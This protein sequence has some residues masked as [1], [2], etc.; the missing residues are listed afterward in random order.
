MTIEGRIDAISQ[1][2]DSKDQITKFCALISETASNTA[3]LQVVANNIFAEDIYQQ[4]CLVVLFV[5]AYPI[6]QQISKK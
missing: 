2:T 3:R 1:L 5:L 6:P 4:V